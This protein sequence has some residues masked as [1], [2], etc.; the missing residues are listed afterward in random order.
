M[1]AVYLQGNVC[2]K[3]LFLQEIE[4]CYLLNIDIQKLLPQDLIHLSFLCPWS[5]IFLKYYWCLWWYMPEHWIF[6][7]VIFNRPVFYWWS[8]GFHF[9][10]FSFNTI[11]DSKHYNHFA[12]N[13][14]TIQCKW[15]I[16]SWSCLVVVHYGF[17]EL[18]KN[19]FLDVI[20]LK[21]KEK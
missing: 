10:G 16:I 20:K 14:I 1:A 5:G 2:W 4:L 19:A 6:I 9:V 15:N 21:D 13:W 12:C 18:I 7:N 11:M 17:N 8:D 3:F